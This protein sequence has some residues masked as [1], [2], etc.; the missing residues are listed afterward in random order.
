MERVKENIYRHAG[1]QIGKKFEFVNALISML[2]LLIVV[3][4][5]VLGFDL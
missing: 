4:I 3:A 1:L 2:W 5:T